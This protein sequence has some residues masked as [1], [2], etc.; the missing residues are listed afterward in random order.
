MRNRQIHHRQGVCTIQQHSVTEGK[1]H[2]DT[3]SLGEVCRKVLTYIKLKLTYRLV[4]AAATALVLEL[5]LEGL[6]AHHQHAFHICILLH[7]LQ[8]RVF[9][10]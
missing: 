7:E 10:L 3:N 6:T 9:Y 1:I 5:A 4:M 8:A 2:I